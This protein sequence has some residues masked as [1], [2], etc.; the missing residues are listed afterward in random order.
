MIRIRRERGFTLIELLVVISILMILMGLLVP[1]LSTA[2]ENARQSACRGNLRQMG[3]FFQQ[4]ASDNEGWFPWGAVPA[5]IDILD[6]NLNQ[7]GSIRP[8]VTN[9]AG[10]GYF[11]DG[12][13]LICPSDKSD[14]PADNFAVA[15]SKDVLGPTFDTRGASSRPS[16]CSY[17]YIAG[18]NEKSSEDFTLA[19]VLTDEANDVE[20]G[21]LQ[22]GHMPPIDDGDNH[23]KA[24][25]NVL[26][27]DCHVGAVKGNDVANSIFSVLKNTV[28]LQS[29]D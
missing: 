17:M 16:N 26:Y 1:A 20:N 5:K 23:G 3:I 22:G 15:A 12:K 21:A 27:L 11:R 18:F 8:V 13:I 6:G 2:R 10:R 19:P 24:F 9:M 28:I 7:Q 14:G 25:R 4:F 29:V